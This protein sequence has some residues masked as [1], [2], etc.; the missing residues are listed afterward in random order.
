M[1]LPAFFP[2]PQKTGWV[3]SAFCFAIANVGLLAVAAAQEPSS[4]AEESLGSSSA[5]TAEDTGSGYWRRTRFGWEDTRS[6]EPVTGLRPEATPGMHPLA[7]SAILVLSVLSLALWASGED[8][9]GRMAPWLVARHDR[10][11]DRD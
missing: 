6:W 10:E 11:E 7:W 9:L 3:R 8:E 1:P 4:P 5:A 2:G